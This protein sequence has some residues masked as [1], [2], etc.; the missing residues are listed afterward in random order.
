MVINTIILL[1]GLLNI[2][3]VIDFRSPY[4]V[5]GIY[6]YIFLY[7]PGYAL[8]KLFFKDKEIDKLEMI[9]IS[10]CVGYIFFYLWVVPAYIIKARL[11]SFILFYIFTVIFLYLIYL[12]HKKSI[13]NIRFANVNLSSLEWFILSIILAAS[14]LMADYYGGFTSGNFLPQITVVRKTVDFNVIQQSSP[15]FKDFPYH[16]IMYHS[17]N[18]LL[19]MF[20]MLGNIDPAK[21]WIYIPQFILPIGLIAHFCFA[22]RFFNSSKVGLIFLVIYFLYHGLYNVFASC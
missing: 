2:L 7:L 21:F 5:L 15:Y 3:G 19:A 18:V 1:I 17:Y 20:T 14:F 10:L 13:T 22:R 6:Y 11:S 9:P 16:Q 12:Y 4:L 8:L